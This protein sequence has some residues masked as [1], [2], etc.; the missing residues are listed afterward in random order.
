MWCPICKNE[1]REGIAFCPDCK[2]ALTESLSEET[3]ETELL[4]SLDEEA[5]AKK[6]AAYLEY[7][8]IT[9]QL[10]EDAQSGAF[11]VLVPKRKLKQAKKAFSAFYTVEVTAEYEQKLAAAL[12]KSR[13]TDSSTEE[14]IE[15]ELS[16]KPVETPGDGVPEGGD[17]LP[18]KEDFSKEDFS[19]EEDG[20][21]GAEDES[22][23]GDASS[24]Q[25][26]PEEDEVEKALLEAISQSSKGSYV[27]RAEKSADYRSSGVT[28]TVFGVLGIIVMILHWAGVFRYFSTV[29]A[30]VISV[31]FLAFLVIGIDSFRR[32]A[33]A[34]E[35]AVQEENFIRE[36]TCWLE[37]NLTLESLCAADQE[38]SSDEVN[39]L[40]RM[41]EFKEIITKQFGELDPGF[42]DQFTEEYYNEHFEKQS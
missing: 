18:E 39:F 11:S 37:K 14:M 21:E 33:R 6:L 25:D 24:K 10:K 5:D 12:E 28:F 41:S 35:E 31:L 38:G 26:A 36:L 27:S 17:R 15:P 34:K 23:A 9:A 30:V 16:G 19:Q 8:G 42:L 2:T 1:Y 22:S 3:E 13:K 20:A 40:N 4:V 29:S 32:A 7:S